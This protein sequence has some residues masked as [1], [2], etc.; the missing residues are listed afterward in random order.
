[1]KNKAGPSAGIPRA[2]GER[3]SPVANGV[4][5]QVSIICTFPCQFLRLLFVFVAL[6]TS[7]LARMYC[8]FRSIVAAAAAYANGR[9]NLSFR[10]SR[11]LHHSSLFIATS[12]ADSF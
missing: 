9:T 10:F 12:S 4:N 6:M 1:M 2:S 3:N 5:G 11:G 8:D 7:F